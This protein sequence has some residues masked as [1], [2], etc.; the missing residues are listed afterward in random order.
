MIYRV[1]YNL[2]PD[3]V[4]DTIFLVDPLAH[5]QTATWNF[6]TVICLNQAHS[7]LGLCTCLSFA[8]SVLQDLFP[9]PSLSV[10]DL[11]V[12]FSN[13]LFLLEEEGES[14]LSRLHTQHAAERGA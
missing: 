4:C 13:K 3:H 9:L 10:L 5:F 12:T 2:A 14:I 7:D 11:D 8:S 1:L 6:L